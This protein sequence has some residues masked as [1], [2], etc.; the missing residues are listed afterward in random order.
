MILLI[1]VIVVIMFILFALF[2]GFG[3]GVADKVSEF[4]SGNSYPNPPGFPE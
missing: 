4:F 1:I 3:E 2:G